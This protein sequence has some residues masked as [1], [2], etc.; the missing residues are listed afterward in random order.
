MS[1]GL[2][3]GAARDSAGPGPKEEVRRHR[4]PHPRRR[5]QV[6]SARS[7]Q[8]STHGPG[9]YKELSSIFADQ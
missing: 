7:T 6:G 9:G 4:H 2:A 5:I 8:F 3:G 1:R